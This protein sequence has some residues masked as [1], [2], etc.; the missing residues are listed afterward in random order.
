MRKK[1]AQYFADHPI[2]CFCIFMFLCFL[3][4][5]IIIAK[6]PD[7]VLIIFIA[8][9]LLLLFFFTTIYFIETAKEKQKFQNMTKE[10]YEKNL[11]Q[12][13]DL[14]NEMIDEEK[15]NP[16]NLSAD[17]ILQFN[18]IMYN[19]IC[20]DENPLGRMFNDFD[21]ASSLIYSLTSDNTTDENILFA[22]HCA[23][24]IISE[25][26]EYINDFGLGYKLELKAKNF[27]QKVNISI[28][29]ETITPE[30]LA[31][32]IR[33]YLMQNAESGMIQLSD[34]LHILY[35]NCK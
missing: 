31:A 13:V 35:L 18:T 30:A 16:N 8:C 20:A 25:P 5:I 29:N 7:I 33:M 6:L 34:F 32:I 23:K 14:V 26:K 27:F 11:Y 1:I 21:I 17:W 12:Y 24:K 10:D 19:T 28:P 2:K 9:M 15:Y 22:F 4:V 3:S